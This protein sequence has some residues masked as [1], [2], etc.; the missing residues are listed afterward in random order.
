MFIYVAT[1]RMLNDKILAV[2]HVIR[3]T[4]NS[5]DELVTVW[6]L[7]QLRHLRRA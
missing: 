3:H 2:S 5:Y 7:D 1:S 6:S 4:I